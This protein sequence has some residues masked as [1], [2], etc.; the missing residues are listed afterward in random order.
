MND[1]DPA[2]G[3]SHVKDL[4]SMTLPPGEGVP[5]NSFF[6]G[7]LFMDTLALAIA[8][9]EDGKLLLSELRKKWPS[10]VDASMAEAEAMAKQDIQTLRATA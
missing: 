4:I 7:M 3:E 1:N 5:A 2:W 6:D 10:G 8:L 9:K